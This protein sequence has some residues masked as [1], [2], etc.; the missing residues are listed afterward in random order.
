MYMCKRIR[1]QRPAVDKARYV[2]SR[3]PLRT[4]SPQV[5]SPDTF[6]RHVADRILVRIEE[7][8]Q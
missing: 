5:R 8:R 1:P 3:Q 4:R 2:L 7:A 6:V